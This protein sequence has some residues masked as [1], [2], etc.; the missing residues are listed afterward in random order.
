[1]TSPFLIVMSNMSMQINGV[2]LVRHI[3]AIWEH[4]LTLLARHEFTLLS[5]VC[6]WKISVKLRLN[7]EHIFREKGLCWITVCLNYHFHIQTQRIT[8]VD[9][10]ECGL[11]LSFVGNKFG[12]WWHHYVVWMRFQTILRKLCLTTEWPSISL[13]PP[14][15]FTFYLSKFQVYSLIL[16]CL[17]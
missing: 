11:L 1:M 7:A 8:V 10:K 17:F 3:L 9:C 2:L 15:V 13:N 12:I 6:R 4:I 14:R 5:W 16:F